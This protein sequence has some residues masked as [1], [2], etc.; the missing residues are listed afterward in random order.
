LNKQGNSWIV[1]LGVNLHAEK[2]NEDLLLND[3]F[4][5]QYLSAKRVK[6]V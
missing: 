3:G 4:K 5:Y 2:T 6:M 1:H